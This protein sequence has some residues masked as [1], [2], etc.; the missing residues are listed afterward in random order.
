MALNVPIPLETAVQSLTALAR[1][2]GQAGV[3]F[4]RAAERASAIT[5]PPGGV[6]PR[7]FARLLSSTRVQAEQFD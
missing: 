3:A 5:A 6:G 7:T 4:D 2:V 1:E